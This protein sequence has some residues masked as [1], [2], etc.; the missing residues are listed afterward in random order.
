MF[1]DDKLQK[2]DENSIGKKFRAFSNALFA[3]IFFIG[4][5]TFA[6]TN[7]Q[8]SYEGIGD[9]L[10]A[11]AE[12]AKL[13]I[14]EVM[15]N[16]LVLC[17]KLTTMSTIQEYF[18]NPFDEDIRE[19][20]LREFDSY[21]GEYAGEK[22]VFWV[23]DN[24]KIFYSSYAAPYVVDPSLPDNYWY[25]KTLYDT[26]LYWYN[27][28]YNP[29]LDIV[30]LWINA[31][32]YTENSFTAASK[33][34]GMLGTGIDLTNFTDE[35]YKDIPKDAEIILFTRSG[36]V[37]FD[38]DIENVVK[39]VNITDLEGVPGMELL[40]RALTLNPD[41]EDEVNFSENAIMYHIEYVPSLD[42]Y[43]VVK[44]PL[45]IATLFDNSYTWVFFAMLTVIAAVIVLSNIFV[46]HIGDE[47]EKRNAE[48]VEANFRAETANR[49][50]SNFL[51]KMSHE[52]R[53]PM[54]AI[55]GM[56]ELISREAIS[57]TARVY[58]YKLKRAANGLLSIINDILDFSKIES[59]KLEIVDSPFRFR[60]TLSDVTSI[61]DTRAEQKS[62]QFKKEIA[63]DIPDILIG[64]EARIRQILINLL[65]NA[66]KYTREGFVHLK[67]TVDKLWDDEIT[68]K[69][70]V[71]DSGIGIEEGNLYKLFDSFSQL[72]A[73][74]NA[75]IEGTG[76]GLAITR[77]LCQAMGGDVTVSSIYG[78]GT[79]FTA[80][81][82]LE[83]PPK[84]EKIVIEGDSERN[85]LQ[86]NDFF[87]PD[88]KVLIVDDIEI[89]VEIAAEL[90][91]IAG[92]K[93]DTALSGR[94]AL[95]KC[96]VE[97][98][99]IIL[100]DH[101]MPEMDG[102]ETTLEIRKLDE[103][104][105]TIPIIALTANAVA[106]VKEMFFENGMNDFVPKPIELKELLAAI[107]RWLPRA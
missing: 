101:M 24:D 14:S 72:D 76:L 74:K 73:K 57:E 100:M 10:S 93:A 46:G 63:F 5:I 102:I 2:S 49:E 12:T 53:T 106:G 29:D 70:V 15:S 17:I 11:S 1:E 39:K 80:T 45:T 82:V 59:G 47:L 71:T 26:D 105:K 7:L 27:V 36:D 4:V 23:N 94:E 83:T 62:L 25:N 13:R 38:K 99:D 6:V 69:V 81:I 20:A 95:D 86:N 104:Y 22:L 92:I 19:A 79:T 107:K 77:S 32:V 51:A 42:W 50:K 18:N 58:I 88:A 67:I 31:P 48:L 44:Y 55:I 56:S 54:N 52:I 64:D 65:S 40:R 89:N 33:P 103:H 96:K 84:G 43:I 21:R 78:T 66:V 34:I 16:E 87:A 60:D 3:V 9:T 97:N 28:N 35:I 68:L 90:L 75:G 85:T 41:R 8:S 61:I 98:Y 30:G 91:T 37:T